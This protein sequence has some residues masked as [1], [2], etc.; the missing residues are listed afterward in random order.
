MKKDYEFTVTFGCTYGSFYEE[1]ED[2]EEAY[3][4]AIGTILDALKELPVQV[5]FD[6]DCLTEDDEEEDWDE[7]DE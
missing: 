1:A 2:F 5:D 6:V 4:K 7:E 3:D